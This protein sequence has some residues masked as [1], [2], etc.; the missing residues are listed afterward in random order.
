MS[1]AIGLSGDGSKNFNIR[2]CEHMILGQLRM[3]ARQTKNAPLQAG[4]L[5]CTD[6]AKYWPILAS[7]RHF[8]TILRTF[9][10]FFPGLNSAVVPINSQISGMFYCYWIWI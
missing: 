1:N 6:N 8:V 7:F 5:F 9:D 4:A 3:C 10:A 2:T